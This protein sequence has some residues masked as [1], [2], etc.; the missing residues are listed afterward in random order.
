[1][2]A[3]GDERQCRQRAQQAQEDEQPVLLV[4]PGVT[5]VRPMAARLGAL[6]DERVGAGIV[7]ERALGGACHGHPHG[8]VVVVQRRH[9]LGRRAAERERHDGY[10]L[11][12]GELQL[13]AI[14]VVVEARPAQ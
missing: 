10:P 2:T 12:H 1:M 9:R 3:G 13:G 7:R 8:D 5:E 11:A 4:L 14:G 6:R